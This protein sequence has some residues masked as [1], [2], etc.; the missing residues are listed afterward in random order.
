MCPM[1]VTFNKM[2][3]KEKLPNIANLLPKLMADS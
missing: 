2:L 1:P 3:D